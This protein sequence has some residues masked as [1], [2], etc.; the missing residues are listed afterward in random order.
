MRD[1]RRHEREFV[2]FSLFSGPAA[3]RKHMS[4]ENQL[5]ERILELPRLKFKSRS[6]Q[7]IYIF[8][9]AAIANGY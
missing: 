4:L 3:I 9:F 8:S 7:Y 5:D 2:D 1:E 6:V